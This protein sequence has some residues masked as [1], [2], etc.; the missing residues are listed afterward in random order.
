MSEQD[1][2]TPVGDISEGFYDILESRREI[3]EGN[4]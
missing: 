2:L 3:V 1:L 4:A